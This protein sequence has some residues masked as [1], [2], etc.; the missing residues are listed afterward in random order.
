M[1]APPSAI[2]QFS[3]LPGFQCLFQFHLLFLPFQSKFQ[4]SSLH[5]PLPI[6]IPLRH[7]WFRHFLSSPL[8]T[9]YSP[10]IPFLLSVLCRP[11]CWFILWFMSGGG[12]RV[13]Y[14]VC[15]QIIPSHPP[16][17]HLIKSGEPSSWR[18]LCGLGPNLICMLIWR[19]FWQPCSHFLP[20]CCPVDCILT[21]WLQL[22]KH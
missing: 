1:T 12:L 13:C 18:H 8:L 5:F 4:V 16:S 19:N 11:P 17:Y 15:S 14:G 10:K 2:R 3:T 9:L 20:N 22:L 21:S 6:R 7:P